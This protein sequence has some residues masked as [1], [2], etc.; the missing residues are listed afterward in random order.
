MERLAKFNFY[1]LDENADSRPQNSGSK[2]LVFSF[3]SK[4]ILETALSEN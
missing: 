4:N 2:G 1:P 3:E